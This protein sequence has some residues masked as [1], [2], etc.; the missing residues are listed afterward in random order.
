MKP[1]EGHATRGLGK[2]IASAA[3][4][5]PHSP[6]T[7]LAISFPCTRV[8]CEAREAHEDVM[9]CDGQFFLLM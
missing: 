2:E 3:I 7:A 4:Q 1:H 9:G 8:C 5:I 6:S